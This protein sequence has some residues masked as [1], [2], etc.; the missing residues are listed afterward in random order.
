MTRPP[1]PGGLLFFMK[2]IFFVFSLLFVSLFPGAQELYVFSEPAS[3]MP[4]NT[5]SPKF[6]AV[7]GKRPG[8]TNYQRYTPELM[9]GF[10]KEFMLHLATSF[11]NMHTP[12]VKWEG[13]YVYGK[14]RFL[15]NDEIHRHFR[16]AAFVEAGYSK[17]P[18]YFDE[19]SV[20]GDNSGVDFGLIATQLVHKL[21]VSATASY[22]KVYGEPAEHVHHELA[23]SAMNYSL[24]AGYL[25][26]PREYTSYD[27]LNFNIYGELIAQQAFGKDAYYIDAAPAI[28]FIFGSNS[29]LNLGYRFQVKGNALRAVEKSYLVS[30]EHTFF[31]ALRKKK[32]R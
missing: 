25:V 13:A 26:L 31:N 1:S 11:S 15:S 6:K 21:A 5:I 17:N 16:M 29:K 22:L 4:A 19:I 23:R 30:F 10:S 32:S 9:L 7:G 28:Q 12:D 2:K 3:N 18:L 8:E 24:S 20:R 14:Y 27:Q